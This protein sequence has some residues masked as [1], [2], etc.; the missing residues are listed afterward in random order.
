[1]AE[2]ERRYTLRKR[3]SSVT[4]RA[5]F[6]CYVCG[7]DTPSSK[8][9]LVYCCSNAEREPYYPFIKSLNAYP[10]ASPISPQGAYRQRWREGDPHN[11]AFK[12]ILSNCYIDFLLLLLLPQAWY[13]SAVRVTRSTRTRQRAAHRTALTAD[14]HR[15]TTNL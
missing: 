1:M 15:R 11:T 7:A 13:K 2:A 14:L 6:V 9:R 3:P 4:E 12:L 5:T 8:L 10:N